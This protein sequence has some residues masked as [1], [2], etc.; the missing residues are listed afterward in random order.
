MLMPVVSV[1][2]VMMV[3]AMMTSA[4]LRQRWGSQSDN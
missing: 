4:R 1:V 2:M 3:V